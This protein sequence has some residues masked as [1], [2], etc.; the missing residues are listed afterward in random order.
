M[1][2]YR[3]SAIFRLVS[4]ALLGTAFVLHP[5]SA[6]AQLF[7]ESQNHPALWKIEN[8]ESVV[9]L[10]G[11]HHILRRNTDWITGTLATLVEDADAFVFE[12]EITEERIPDAQDFIDESGFLPRGASLNTMLSEETRNSLRSLL[13]GLPLDPDEVDRL[14]PWLA[15]LTLSSAY[16]GKRRYTVEA[17]ADV[18][19]MGAAF[20]AEKPIRYFETPRQ[21]LEYFAEAMR[22]APAEGFEV[23]VD[24]LRN[25]PD[26]IV[27]NVRAWRAGNVEEMAASIRGFFAYNPDALRI[28][29]DERNVEWA[30]QIEEMLTEEQTI[31]ITVGVG[32]LGGPG[33]II[34]ILC[35]NGWSVER[36]PTDGEEVPQACS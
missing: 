12:A 17:G 24:S 22:H 28:L 2:L 23:V 21:Q 34:E 31:F 1:S 6:R 15:M 8:G 35:R 13:R 7:L 14:E 16:Y 18:R 29:L 26:L 32:H 27:E 10:F 9:Y 19:I 20:R 3:S 33:S 5:V 11:S 36:V 25:D 30:T 4:L